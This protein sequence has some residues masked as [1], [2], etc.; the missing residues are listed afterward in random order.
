MRTSQWVNLI[1]SLTQLRRLLQ[2]PSARI[3]VPTVVADQMRYLG[4]NLLRAQFTGEA[5]QERIEDRLSC[6]VRDVSNGLGSD[7]PAPG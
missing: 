4:R 3:G 5:D 1:D 7:F 2:C 6:P